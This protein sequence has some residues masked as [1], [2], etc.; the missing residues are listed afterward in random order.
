MLFACFGA[1][2]LVVV[3]TDEHASL[4]A[5]YIELLDLSSFQ[6]RMAHCIV[7]AFKFHIKTEMQSKIYFRR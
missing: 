7:A 2:R 1:L 3:T 6:L 5:R 4:V